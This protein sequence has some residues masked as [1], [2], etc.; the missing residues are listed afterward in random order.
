MIENDGDFISNQGL[1]I[2]PANNSILIDSLEL[3]LC[4]RQNGSLCL[5]KRGRC[6]CQ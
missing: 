6:T 1:I 2:E 3:F 5:G 4:R